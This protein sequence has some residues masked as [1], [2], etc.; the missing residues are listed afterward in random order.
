MGPPFELLKGSPIP[1]RA[2]VDQPVPR[3][4]VAVR[5][6]IVSIDLL[7]GAI[8]IL[9]ALDH[10]RDFFGVGGL[11]ARDVTDPALFLTRWVTHYCAP[12]F[13]LLAGV[14]AYLYGTSGRTV[15]D[16]SRFLLTRGLWL[17][18]IEFTVVR[19]GWFF[20]LN[21]HLFFAQ[22]IWALGVSMVVL[23]GL[24][25]LP[26]WAIAAVGLAMIGGHNLFDGI[27]PE[28]LGAAGWIWNLLHRPGLL[29]LGPA[30]GFY[31]SY[32]LVPWIGVMAA[33]YAFGWVMLREPP[34]RDRL[35]LS[36]GLGAIALFLLLRGFNLYGNPSPWGGQNSPM[37]ALLSFLNTNKYP[38]SLLFL[39]MTLGPTIAL[40][41][42][43][44]RARGAL[45]RW[46][47]VFG[48]VP[49]F[50]YL[51]HI[52]L[53]HLVALLISLVRTPGDTAWLFTNHPMMPP[54]VPD[55]YMWSLALLYG[56]TLIV[57]VI[58]YFPCR[59]FAARKAEGVHPL[60]KFL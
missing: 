7:R 47:T 10:T 60:L 17:I 40:I 44:E 42:I 49:M 12:L 38:A 45:A 19:L 32:P 27:R 39:L 37:P 31:L 25:Y 29:Q 46:L 26:R 30:A 34:R 56:V 1:R 22:V 55:G 5:P 51:L 57:V 14:S 4:V 23:S 52:P 28:H 43:L 20:S 24:V 2:A 6:R 9:M 41:P 48:R 18:V 53:I 58:L 59:W 13:I 35:C 21:L 33:G 50:Y 36:I 11:N 16:V 3:L 15:A 54:D 8:M